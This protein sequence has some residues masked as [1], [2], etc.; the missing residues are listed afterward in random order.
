MLYLQTAVI[1][2]GLIQL[3]L[4]RYD[5]CILI[6]FSAVDV[7][8]ARYCFVYITADARHCCQSQL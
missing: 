3:L 7:C 8:I 1:I 2:C 6:V 5:H 4:E